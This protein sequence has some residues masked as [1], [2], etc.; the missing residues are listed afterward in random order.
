MGLR[1]SGASADKFNILQKKAEQQ[2][3]AQTQEQ[4]DALKRRFAALGA[5]GSGEA[6]KL[7]QQAGEQGAQ[8]LQSARE[9]IEFAKLD[10]QSRLDAEQ[11]GRDFATS[12]RL[13]SQAFGAGETA[14]GRKF[15]SE[16]AGLQRGFLTGERL[17][18]QEFQSGQADTQRS[19]LTGERIGAQDFATTERLGAQGFATTERLGAQGFAT[20]EREGTQTFQSAENVLN[21]QL[22]ANESLLQ[23]NFEGLMFDQ[24][25]AEDVRVTNENLKIAQKEANKKNPGLIGGLFGDVNL[26]LPGGG[27]GGSG[28]PFSGFGGGSSLGSM[29]GQ[30]AVGGGLFS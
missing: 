12:E 13:G 1:I 20:T 16:Q 9:G 6:I 17:G 4:K 26:S 18:S 5:Q 30:A 10:E 14:L 22:T 7:E 19:F 29:A 21:R 25:F 8:R 28:N 2:A 27:G 3:T 23:R 11:R 24:Q 15:A